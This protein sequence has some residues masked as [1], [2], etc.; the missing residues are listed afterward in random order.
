MRLGELKVDG[1]DGGFRNRMAPGEPGR[2][3]S[4]LVQAPVQTLLKRFLHTF[5][6]PTLSDVQPQ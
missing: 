5:A 3:T 6:H 2:K 1:I 4:S